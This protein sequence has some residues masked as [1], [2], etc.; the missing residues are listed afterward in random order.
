MNTI[1]YTT[2]LGSLLIQD[3]AISLSQRFFA[4]YILFDLYKSDAP[5]TNPFLPIF[6]DE[7]SLS[8]RGAARFATDGAPCTG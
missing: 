4:F 6:I 3:R 2:F 5:G 7:V 8:L 1:A